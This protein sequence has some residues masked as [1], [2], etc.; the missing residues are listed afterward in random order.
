MPGE[1][2]AGAS[3]NR[4]RS[5]GTGL[6]NTWI[7]RPQFENSHGPPRLAVKILQTTLDGEE[8]DLEVLKL[9]RDSRA[10]VLGSAGL[11]EELVQGQIEKGR[12][13]LVLDLGTLE[14]VDSSGIGEVVAAFRLTAGSSS[15]VV[16][17][18]LPPKIREIFRRTEL[19]RMIPV[20]DSVAEAVRHFG[21]PDRQS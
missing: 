17:A 10:E 18:N 9:E 8:S 3:E 15:E 11:L 13:R 21:D 1:D 2:A 14:K 5:S 4:H 7:L 19:D 12:R 6:M 20:Y 16:L